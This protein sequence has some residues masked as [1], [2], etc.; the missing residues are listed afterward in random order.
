MR[1]LRNVLFGFIL[2]M[3]FTTVLRRYGVGV[4]NDIF[5][6]AEGN[7]SAL[8]FRI[9]HRIDIGFCGLLGLVF[10]ACAMIEPEPMCEPEEVTL[11]TRVS[12]YIRR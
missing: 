1:T 6:L 12:G 2:L 10:E 11:V 9:L 5:D 4:F 8:V 3:I 7:V